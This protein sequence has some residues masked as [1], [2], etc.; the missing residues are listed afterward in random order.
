MMLQCLDL[1]VVCHDGMAVADDFVFSG[2]NSNIENS[3]LCV[4][5][6]ATDHFVL[7]KQIVYGK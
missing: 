5:A 6:H 3:S 2:N 4:L 7:W 1:S